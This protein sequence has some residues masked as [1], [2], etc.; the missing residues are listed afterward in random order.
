MELISWLYAATLTLLAVF[1]F[2][3][4]FLS[5]LGLVAGRLRARAAPLPALP[6]RAADWPAVLVQLPLFNERYVAER[7]IDAVAAQ[8]YPNQRLL[9]QVLDDS[10]DDTTAIARARVAYHRAR[11]LPI[12]L[13]HRSDRAGFKAGALA[14]GLAAAP[15]DLV[16]VFDADFKPPPDF[17]RRVV[18]VFADQPRLALLQTRWEHLNAEQDA[19]TRAQ[20][21]A[22]DGYFGV[23]QVARAD[24]GLLM[25]FN[26]SAGVWRRAAIEDAG[27]WQGDTLAED[28]DLSYRAQLRG[29]RLA[30][31]ADVAA[32]AELPT[33]VM[34]FKGQQFRWAKGSF[35]VMR[36]LGWR[37][38][39]APRISPFHKLQGLLH[40][41]GYLPH[42]LMVATLLLSLPLV[43]WNNGASPARWSVLGLA[44]FGPPLLVVL[45]Q[46]ALRKDWP[47]RLLYYPVLV[48]LGI[49]LACANT[50]ALWEAFA[51]QPSAFMRTP[52]GAPGAGSDYA[53]SIDWTTWGE[54]F[55][56]G[57]ALVTGLLALEL[58]PG[59]APFIF[60]Y[61]LG[62]GFTALLGLWQSDPVRQRKNKGAESAQ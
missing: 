18:P 24:G 53:L 61:A 54:L 3:L 8:D 62:F 1:G 10:T 11:G 46:L 59:M 42:P 6:E 36:K 52:K 5:L 33:S 30:Y 44:G 34:A 40:L 22:L 32:P 19:V 2:N 31:R 28:L 57:Y 20:A 58:A 12:T 21:L 43:L 56:A 38:L 16:A 29:W 49:G 39:A 41:L 35:Q 27:G 47:R 45:G 55:L 51:G 26:G 9:I 15:G 13:L 23:E 17:L 4:I 48:L 37:L 25:N 7:L 60:L 50:R 14:A